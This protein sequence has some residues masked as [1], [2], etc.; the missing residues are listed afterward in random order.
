MSSL[1]NAK[2]FDAV[3]ENGGTDIVFLKQL[4][5]RQL[6]KFVEFVTTDQTPQLVA[7][8]AE[9]DLEWVDTLTL[10]SYGALAA[11]CMKLN[12]LRATALAEK[13]TLVAMKLAPLNMKVLAALKQAMESGAI[14]KSSL[15]ELV[16][17]AS[18][19]ATGSAPSTAPRTA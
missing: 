15:D 14:T 11:E 10:E 3:L 12:F 4:T 13:D 17:S 7:L 16:R 19:G 6:Y 18:A 2:K 8:C 1:V 5:I 9:R